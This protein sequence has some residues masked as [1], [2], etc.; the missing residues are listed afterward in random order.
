MYTT[1]IQHVYNMYTTYIQH[2]YNIYTTYIRKTRTVSE[3]T[4]DP[5]ILH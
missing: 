3:I 2:V 1:Y 4:K 5:P